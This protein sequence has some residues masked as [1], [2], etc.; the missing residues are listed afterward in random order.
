MVIGAALFAAH[1]WLRRPPREQVTVS[2]DFI[3][4]LR[5][6]HRRRAG[7]APTPEET[8][9]LIERHVEEEVLHREALALGLDAGDI[10]VRRRLVQKMQFL[11]EAE[12]EA[13]EPSEGELQ[14]HLSANADRYRAPAVISFRHVFV[15]RDRHGERAKAEATRL[16][17]AL[18]GGADPAV[19]GEPF[20]QGSV[21]SKRS[22][23]EIEAT[24][25]A[26]FAEGAFT[27]KQGAWAGPIE[28]SYG[29]HVVL[30]SD[31]AEGRVPALSEV[32]AKVRD[33]WR[34][35]R[36]EEVR[37]AAMDRLRARYRVVIDAAE[38][39]P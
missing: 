7:R 36:R 29:A 15:S 3:E 37:R 6:E 27:M 12:S 21:W 10:I 35:A 16:L 8:R 33:D 18:R 20:L 2:A 24:F 19:L 26:T 25:G 11:L 28:S 31:R 17:E 38:G 1:A 32:R 5:E 14:A 9:G 34:A 4:G 30:V 23:K 39:A 13:I 22:A